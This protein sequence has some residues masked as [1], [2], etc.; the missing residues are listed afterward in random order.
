MVEKVKRNKFV[1]WWKP[2]PCGTLDYIF[3][4]FHLLSLMFDNVDLYRNIF[5]FCE[6]SYDDITFIPFKSS[7][8]IYFLSFILTFFYHFHIFSFGLDIIKKGKTKCYEASWHVY[9]FLLHTFL[10]FH[11]A[12]VTYPILVFHY[13]SKYALH[14]NLFP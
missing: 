6:L 10:L 12:F 5:L 13:L 14:E 9:S 4:S 8:H 3:H 7:L 1:L 2:L 11:Y